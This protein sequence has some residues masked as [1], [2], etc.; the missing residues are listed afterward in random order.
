MK[1]EKF[2]PLHKVHDIVQIRLVELDDYDQVVK[3]IYESPEFEPQHRL[4]PDVSNF[5]YRIVLDQN[6]PHHNIKFNDWENIPPM[7]I[8]ARRKDSNEWFYLEDPVE[9]Y[10]NL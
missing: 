3:V 9:S 4:G 10:M 5:S 7:E 6:I 2:I 8:Q 1:K